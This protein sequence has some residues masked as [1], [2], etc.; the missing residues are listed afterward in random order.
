MTGLIRNWKVKTEGISDTLDSEKKELLIAALLSGDYKQGNGMLCEE[1]WNGRFYCCLGVGAEIS[2][3]KFRVDP[4]DEDNTIKTIEYRM[5]EELRTH[6]SDDYVEYRWC[7][8]TWN[9]DIAAWFGTDSN[10]PR[11]F[12]N[13]TPD[14]AVYFEHQGITDPNQYHDGNFLEE[15]TMASC[16]DELTL[17]FAQIADLVKMFL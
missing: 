8:R 16:N 2:P 6:R 7:S 17:T 14:T 11:I 10:N 5:P 13:L 15:V 4:G 3:A 12:R 9:A 1:K